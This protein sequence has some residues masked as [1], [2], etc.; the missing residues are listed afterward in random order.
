M[1]VI[2]LTERIQQENVF[3]FACNYLQGEFGAKT[4]CLT[5]NQEESV[6][7]IF[8][9]AK[10]A[11]KVIV[12]DTVQGLSLSKSIKTIFYISSQ[13]G[14]PYTDTNTAL[15]RQLQVRP[16]V[17]VVCASLYL[18]RL[19][20][21][22]YHIKAVVQYPYVNIN[23]QANPQL[24]FYN[25]QN[26]IIDGL[27][28]ELAESF[29][30]YENYCELCLAKLYIHIPEYDEACNV[31][32]PLA[33]SW[34][35]PT[36]TFD[37]GCLI[38]MIS[39]GDS[40]LPVNANL[41]QWVQGVKI[42]MRDRDQNSRIVHNSSKRWSNLDIIAEKVRQK[43]I[44]RMVSKGFSQPNPK[45]IAEPTPPQITQEQLLAEKAAKA[46]QRRVNKPAPIPPPPAK[47]AKKPVVTYTRSPYVKPTERIVPVPAWFTQFEPKQIDVSIIVPM[48]RS[49]EVISQQIR[50]W[51]VADDGLRKEII[52]VDDACPE[53]SS[54]HV[55]SAW[56][57]FRAA[58]NNM[59]GVYGSEFKGHIGKIIALSH[60]SGYAT[61]C[62]VGAKYAKGRFLIFLNADCI[63]TPNWVHPM[64]EIFSDNVGIVGNMQLKQNGNIDSA[65]SEWHWATKT[66]EHIGRNIYSGKRLTNV[67][68]LTDAPPDLLQVAPREMVTGC[69]FAIPK[70][71]FDDLGGYDLGYRIS[72]WEDSDLNM[73]VREKG[74]EILFQPNSQVFHR[75]SHANSGNH[76]FMMD[77]AKR[78]Y[79]KWVDN[80]KI[81]KFVKA[82]R[83]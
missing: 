6:T 34:G 5:P 42:A 25:K 56:D 75:G 52:Y 26:G 11:P 83:P 71:L 32:I 76:P 54:A 47:L 1:S 31:R 15:R 16:E 69:C 65:G 48:F 38:E 64:I 46:I 4:V 8:E 44:H 49:S 66:F 51:D 61:A 55:V 40:L 18:S 67:M 19:L 70:R 59:K 9:V 78:F 41:K 58:W 21:R 82:L 20:Y 37:R 30:P 80:G 57:Q 43:A 22:N 68:R 81:D 12:T 36:V 3:Q 62:N 50:N 17:D 63:V 39:K 14:K 79:E 27:V 33:S 35:I 29:V 53:Q 72:Y 45:P 24:I 28:N 10:M 60:N 2:C 7:D 74:Y 73:Q 77:N 13:D 23:S